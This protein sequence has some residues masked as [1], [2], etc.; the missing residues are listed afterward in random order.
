MDDDNKWVF[1]LELKTSE[2]EAPE[3]AGMVMVDISETCG[4]YRILKEE[5]K[6]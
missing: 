1:L 3:T 5:N 4:K 2:G 6:G